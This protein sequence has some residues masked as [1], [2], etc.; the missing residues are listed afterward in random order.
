MSNPSNK[1]EISTTTTNVNDPHS[2]VGSESEAET[3]TGDS[4]SLDSLSAQ[5]LCEELVS[6]AKDVQVKLQF[7]CFRFITRKRLTYLNYIY[8]RNP[9]IIFLTQL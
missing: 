1:T 8:F 2:T 9:V 3:V 6:A 7:C 4:E 5:K